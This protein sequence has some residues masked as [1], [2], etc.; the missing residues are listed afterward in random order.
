MNFRQL[1]LSP[2]ATIAVAAALIGTVSLVIGAHAALNKRALDAAKA[3]TTD[4]DHRL[5]QPELASRAGH[6]QRTLSRRQ[7]CR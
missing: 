2:A 1:D 3:V 4:L 7:C 6:W 5:D